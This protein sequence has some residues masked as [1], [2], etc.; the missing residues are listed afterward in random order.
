MNECV[1]RRAFSNNYRP[2]RIKGNMLLQQT[3]T[4]IAAAVETRMFTIY[5]VVER[6]ECLIGQNLHDRLSLAASQ[7]VHTHEITSYNIIIRYHTRCTLLL[8]YCR[9]MI[10]RSVPE[11]S[12]KRRTAHGYHITASSAPSMLAPH[13]V[14]YLQY[15]YKNCVTT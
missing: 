3:S 14:Q 12:Y 5:Y 6:V 13:Y 7:Y 1:R 15:I 8:D 10:C 2:S 4:N 11:A 9:I